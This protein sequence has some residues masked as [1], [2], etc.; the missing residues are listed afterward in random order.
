MADEK[1]RP[2]GEHLCFAA[3]SSPAKENRFIGDVLGKG[4]LISLCHGLRKSAL[5]RE[6]L[7]LKLRCLRLRRRADR[8]SS[9]ERHSGAEEEVREAAL[10]HLMRPKKVVQ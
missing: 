3:Q 10:I 2:P 1:A 6:H 7:C 8:Q 5:G 9:D 4:L